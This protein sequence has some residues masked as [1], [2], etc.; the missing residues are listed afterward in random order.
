MSKEMRDSKTVR[1]MIIKIGIIVRETILK[2]LE[3]EDKV[4]VILEIICMIKVEAEVDMTKVLMLDIQ[5]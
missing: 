4:E 2:I 1:I 3:A 5:G